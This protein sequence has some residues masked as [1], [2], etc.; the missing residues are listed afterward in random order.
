MPRL[1]S[2]W[3][4][5][6]NALMTLG[7]RQAT[8][9]RYALW[10]HDRDLNRKAARNAACVERARQWT[11]DHPEEARARSRKAREARR[12]RRMEDPEYMERYHVQRRKQ[13]KAYR[14]TEQ[15]KRSVRADQLK[16]KGWTMERYDTS[17]QEQN[18]CCAICREPFTKT[19]AADHKHSDPPVP[20]GLLCGGCNSLL[21]FAKDQP[22]LCESAASYLRKFS[23]TP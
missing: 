9:E 4:A 11:L 2:Y 13:R 17:M 12:A 22:E 7:Q 1:R 15:G 21:G 14:R 10:Q 5:K 6:A 23:G 8:A 16:P 19:P 3:N 18:N 20:R